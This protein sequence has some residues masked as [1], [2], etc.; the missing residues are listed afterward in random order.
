MRSSH[1]WGVAGGFQLPLHLPF[2]D[3]FPKA[4]RTEKEL[5]F[6]RGKRLLPRVHLGVLILAQGAVMRL[7]SSWTRI[8]SGAIC[9]SS[10][11]IWEELWS[12]VCQRRLPSTKWYSRESPSIGPLPP[13][14][15]HDKDDHRG[16][17]PAAF[18]L[19]GEHLRFACS[20]SCRNSPRE[21]FPCQPWRIV[22][23]AAEEAAFPP[24]WP[25]RPSASTAHNRWLS[26]L[27]ISTVSSLQGR[28]PLSV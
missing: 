18:G 22:C 9:P 5:V 8:C 1:S 11:A 21:V 12:F 25:P 15:L 10:T 26:C 28:P 17:H 20:A 6:P 16:L 27:Q 3:V 2:Q 23:T 4:V 7:R 19:Q 13:G 14:A 24:P